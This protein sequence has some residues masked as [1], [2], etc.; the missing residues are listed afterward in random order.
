MLISATHFDQFG[1]THLGRK[2]TFI[3]IYIKK[4]PN[5]LNSYILINHESP[6]NLSTKKPYNN[7]NNTVGS[8]SVGALL[9]S[10]TSQQPV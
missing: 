1:G 5:H 9:T 2:A 7:N 6:Y 8:P 4:D 10:P 3:Y